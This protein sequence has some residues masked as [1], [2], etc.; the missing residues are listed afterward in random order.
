MRHAICIWTGSQQKGHDGL[1]ARHRYEFRD[2]RI[3]FRNNFYVQMFGLVVGCWQ[4]AL[5]LFWPYPFELHLHKRH[6]IKSTVATDSDGN[7][8]TFRQVAKI[9]KIKYN[10]GI[11]WRKIKRMIRRQITGSDCYRFGW[12]RRQY[13]FIKLNL[14]V[15]SLLNEFNENIANILE[16]WQEFKIAKQRANNYITHRKF[17]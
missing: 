12:F 9:N 3:S 1:S 6:E 8:R 14:W 17:P 2:I 13:I 16:L 11:A 5:L 10:F 7:G 15:K 4:L